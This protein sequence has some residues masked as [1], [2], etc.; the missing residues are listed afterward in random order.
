MA[1]L[2]ARRASFR[3]LASSE[4]HQM[5]SFFQS[6]FRIG[7]AASY[8]GAQIG[9]GPNGPVP[10]IFEKIGPAQYFRHT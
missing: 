4:F 1:F 5:L 9:P 6:D 2:Q 10:P 7:Q 3:G 8:T